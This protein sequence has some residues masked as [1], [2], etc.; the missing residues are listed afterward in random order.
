MNLYLIRHGKACERS[1][2]WRPDSARPLTRDGEKRIAEVAAGL[3]ALDIELDL[4]LTSPYIRAFG[5]AEILGEVFG[6]KKLFET[7]NLV[8][9]A[10][11]E[12]IIDEIKESFN[13]LNEIALV[14]HEPFLSRLASVLLTGK[15]STPINMRKGGCCK[16]AIRE[17]GFGPCACLEWLMTPGQLARVGKRAKK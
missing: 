9:E 6:A 10:E 13:S 17:L 14:S 4:I 11:P 7:R 12:P 5:T 3:Q 8:P 16:L 2:H 1:R 15:D